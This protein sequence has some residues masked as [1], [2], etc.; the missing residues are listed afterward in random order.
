ML[1]TGGSTVTVTDDIISGS[2]GGTGWITV[3]DGSTLTADDRIFALGDGNGGQGTLT[4]R[5]PDTIMTV[6]SWARFGASDGSEGIVEVYDGATLSIGGFIR[7]AE[8]AGSQGTIRV[9]DGGQMS[10]GGV[11]D[12]GGQA[13]GPGGSGLL[14]VRNG[15]HFQ[16]TDPDDVIRVRHDGALAVEA[17]LVQ[18]GNITFASDPGA[19]FSVT[20]A[21]GHF[22]ALVETTDTL[23]LGGAEIQLSLGQG[24]TADL[25]DVFVL[26]N[27]DDTG[28]LLGEFANAAQGSIL[29]VGLYEF[30]IDYQDSSMFF[31]DQVSLLTVAIPEPGT[32]LLFLATFPVWLLARRR[33]FRS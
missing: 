32:A 24:F 18:A 29:S 13:S 7:L 33:R 6:S 8:E 23:D 9:Y 31:P 5:N 16:L 10:V 12:V 11:V 25:G 26:M 4:V 19:I 28:T 30:Q 22:D 2:S 17:G 14:E 27:Y 3:E 21:T 1:V 15:G 20:L